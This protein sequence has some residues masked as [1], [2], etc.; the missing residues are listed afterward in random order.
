MNAELL[1]VAK[2]LHTVVLLFLLKK[3]EVFVVIKEQPVQQCD[4]VLKVFGQH[5]AQWNS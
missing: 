2:Y 1:L 3:N 5:G 4:V